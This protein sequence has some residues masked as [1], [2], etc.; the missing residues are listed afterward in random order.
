MAL[1]LG[2]VSWPAV[3]DCGISCSYSLVFIYIYIYRTLIKP[4]GINNRS[5]FNK[6]NKQLFIVYNGSF[7][8]MKTSSTKCYVST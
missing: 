1:P 7:K 5:C 3:C 6:I 8:P 2:A 4:N